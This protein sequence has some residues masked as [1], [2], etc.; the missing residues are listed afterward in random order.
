MA[1]GKASFLMGWN[2]SATSAYEFDDTNASAAASNSAVW[3]SNI[4]QPSGAYYTTDGINRRDFSG[5]MALVN[6]SAS[7]TVTD[8]LGG[9]YTNTAN[10]QQITSITLGPTSGAILSTD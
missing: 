5:G 2:G 8:N 10:G 7:A 3:T 9:T 6:S 1:Y 4:G